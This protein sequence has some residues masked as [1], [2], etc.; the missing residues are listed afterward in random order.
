MRSVGCAAVLVVAIVGLAG[1]QETGFTS[2]GDSAAS[3]DA[4]SDVSFYPTDQLITLGKTQFKDK[5]Y[6]KSYALFKRAVDVFP[7]DPQAWVGLAASADE[8][9]RFDT[10][11][12]AYGKLKPMIGNTAVYYNNIGYS[13]LLRGK[14][15]QA[16]RYFLKAYE[17]DPKNATT[18]NNLALMD[19]SVSVANRPYQ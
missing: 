11:D 2:F 10:S 19:N 5:N 13:Y 17:L 7:N 9:G 18:A 4:V 15:P 12:I 6:G 16:R 8:I 1:C 3:I 14:L